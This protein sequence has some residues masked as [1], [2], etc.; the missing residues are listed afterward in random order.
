MAEEVLNALG[1]LKVWWF[2]DSRRRPDEDA[3]DEDAPLVNLQGGA[4][5]D[6]SGKRS[7][8]AWPTPFA[9]WMGLSNKCNF[10]LR[11]VRVNHS[12]SS[13]PVYSEQK[14]SLEG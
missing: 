9:S 6:P 11:N 14:K 1:V 2:G 7:N 5:W 13:L 12:N 3:P 10:W 4:E 8:V